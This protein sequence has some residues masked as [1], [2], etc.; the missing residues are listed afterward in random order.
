MLVFPL[1]GSW[2]ELPAAHAAAVAF[3]LACIGMLW[4]GGADPAGVN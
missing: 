1:S 3:D 2:D 4:L